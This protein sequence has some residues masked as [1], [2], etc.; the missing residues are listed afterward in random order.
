M[1]PL[2]RIVSPIGNSTSFGVSQS[3]FNETF[4]M[5]TLLS[6]VMSV[7]ARRTMLMWHPIWVEWQLTNGAC[8]H[9]GNCGVS[10]WGTRNLAHRWTWQRPGTWVVMANRHEPPSRAFVLPQQSSERGSGSPRHRIHLAKGVAY[11]TQVYQP[12]TNKTHLLLTQNDA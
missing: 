8:N 12:T 4:M 5:T 2:P 7:V 10:T 3:I 11:L 6:C 1:A 9:E